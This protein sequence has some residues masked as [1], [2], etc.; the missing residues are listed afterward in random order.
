MNFV[1]VEALTFGLGKLVKAA[2]ELDAT[3]HLLTYNRN[4]Y[5][6]ELEK[7]K[8][9][10]LVLVEIDTFKND[11]VIEYCRKLE[12]FSGI[13]NLTDTWTLSVQEISSILGITGQNPKSTSIC[14]NKA[15]LRK[16]LK[17]NDLTSGVY[18][19]VDLSSDTVSEDFVFPVIIKDP[20]GTGSK[21]VWFAED[22]IKANNII[23]AEKK[24]KNLKRLL[25]ETYF[26]GTLYSV[27]TISFRGETRVIAVSSRVL[28]DMPLFMEKAISLPINAES[29]ELKGVEEWIVNVLTAISYTDGFAHTEFIV[30]ANGF[31]VVE[32]NPRLGGVQ[33]G[34]ALCQAYNYNVYKAFIE[35]AMGVRPELFDI[36]LIP[37]TYTGQVFIYASE[38]GRFQKIND[39]LINKDRTKIYPCALPGK[40]IISVTDQS[41]CVAILLTTAEN[42]E[43]ALLNALSE[44]NKALVLMD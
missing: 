8:T 20:T 21:N 4:I 10:R 18:T 16:I 26:C 34:E 32:V 7:I 12:G 17:E 13:I 19:D 30:T 41:A 29:S 27:E 11:N 22:K 43:M 1:L 6:Y 24:N 44:A 5:F 25:V 36:E 3:L 42:S 39:T 31:E 35:M 23:L 40:E 9:N 14:R 37:E 33:I 15:L 2:E 28:S 38:P